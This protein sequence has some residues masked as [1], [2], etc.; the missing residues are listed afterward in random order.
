MY[1]ILVAGI[2]ASGKSFFA[3]YLSND[4]SIP[5]ISKDQIKELLFD[6]VGF[7]SRE[8]KKRINEVAT[9]MMYFFARQLMKSGQPFILESNFEVRTKEHISE[10]LRQFDYKSVT[11]KLSGDYKIIYERFCERNRSAG[12]HPGHVVN[13]YYPRTVTEADYE[14][15]TYSK[16]VSGIQNRGMDTFDVGGILFQF[17]TTDIGKF[18][19]EMAARQVKKALAEQGEL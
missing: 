11:I 13:D 3:D 12:R 5:L 19:W 14:Q 18:D 4:L 2:P 8:E 1:C 15:L 16:F 7:R 10:L 6:A 9:E 17:D